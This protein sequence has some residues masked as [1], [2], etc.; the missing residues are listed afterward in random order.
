MAMSLQPRFVQ[1]L[2]VLSRRIHYKPK[3]S[4]KVDCVDKKLWRI[5][6]TVS[7]LVVGSNKK[8]CG[9]TKDISDFLVFVG[10]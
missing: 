5:Q 10:C 4:F 7:V 8:V 3:L 6:T 9:A 1:V 2:M